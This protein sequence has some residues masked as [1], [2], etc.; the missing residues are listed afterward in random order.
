M[1]DISCIPCSFLVCITM[2]ENTFTSCVPNT[3]QPRY[4]PVEYVT[5]WPFLVTYNKCNIIVFSNKATCVEYFDDI[6]IGVLD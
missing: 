1:C 2:L 3:P 4:N 5:Y 6:H